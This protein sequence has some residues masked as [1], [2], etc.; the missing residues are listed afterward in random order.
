MPMIQLDSLLE[1][2]YTY[3]NKARMEESTCCLIFQN[4]I[5]SEGRCFKGQVEEP[6][7]APAG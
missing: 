5:L 2:Y 4:Q 1:A 7:I 6:T 3:W